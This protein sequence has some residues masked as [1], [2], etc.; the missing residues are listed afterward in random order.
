M[1]TKDKLQ[2]QKYCYTQVYNRLN[3]IIGVRNSTAKCAKEKCPLVKENHCVCHTV[4]LPIK[5]YLI[6]YS[7][8]IIFKPKR[9][10]T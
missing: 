2:P 4:S 5:L 1:I 9:L 10:N 8:S 3:N 6:I 7:L